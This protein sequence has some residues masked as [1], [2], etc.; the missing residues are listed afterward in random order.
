MVFK[1]WNIKWAGNHA[2]ATAHAFIAPPD[3][4]TFFRLIHRLCEAC[5]GASGLITVHTLFF[6]KYFSFGSIVTIDYTA[7]VLICFADFSNFWLFL[8]F[9]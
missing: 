6:D 2:V 7:P 5:S 9:W 8:R 4:R 1:F 3:D